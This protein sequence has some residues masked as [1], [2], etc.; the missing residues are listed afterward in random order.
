MTLS[1]LAGL[2]ACGSGAVSGKS[3]NQSSPGSRIARVQVRSKLLED[4]DN[5]G[6]AVV[7]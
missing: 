6:G 1:V 7:R 3:L 2:L 4:D 5:V